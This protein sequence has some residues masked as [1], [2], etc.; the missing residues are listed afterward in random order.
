[1]HGTYNL[2]SKPEIQIIRS[3]S[4]R[5]ARQ[6]ERKFQFRQGVV[7]NSLKVCLEQK[8]V[9]QL[10]GGNKPFFIGLEIKRLVKKFEPCSANFPQK[11]QH[12]RHAEF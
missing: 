10:E 6:H 11:I 3:N 12:V 9:S 1:M 4:R 7:N 2:T 8:K 5:V